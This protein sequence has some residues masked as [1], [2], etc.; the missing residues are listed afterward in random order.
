M[1]DDVEP[2]SSKARPLYMKLISDPELSA[3]T[4]AA[5]VVTVAV[6]YLSSMAE[7]D[8]S[9]AVRIPARARFYHWLQGAAGRQVTLWRHVEMQAKLRYDLET[10]Q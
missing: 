4:L 2:G 5:A 10:Y 8:G 7:R 6:V 9:S 3:G 1:A